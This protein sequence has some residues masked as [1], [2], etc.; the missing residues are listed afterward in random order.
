[1]KINKWIFALI[2]AAA[3]C[4]RFVP[5]PPNFTPVI[6][7]AVMAVAHFQSRWLQFGFPLLIMGLSDAIIGYHSLVPVVYG[8]IFVASLAGYIYRNNLSFSKF[9]GAG[10]LSSIL[11]F[12]I[13]NFG[14]WAMSTSYPN[15]ISGLVLCYTA[16]IPFFH[17]TVLST[18]GTMMGLYGIQYIISQYAMPHRVLETMT[19]NKE[20]HSL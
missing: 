3:C 6:A 17:N 5:H 10:L 8:A 4:F 1:M 9:L 15:T 11:F 12:L 13:S 7:I 19:L 20:A 18:V 14:V 2:L 16:A